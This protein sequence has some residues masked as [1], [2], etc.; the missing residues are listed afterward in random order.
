MVDDYQQGS[1]IKLV[2]NPDYGL[3]EVYLDGINIR[4]LPDEAQRLNTLTTGGIH[5]TMSSD[6]QTLANV[7]DG[8]DS[9]SVPQGGGQAMFLNQATEP[10]SDLRARQA[11][12]Y[13]VDAAALNDSLFGG[14]FDVVDTLFPDDSPWVGDVKLTGGDAAKAQEL[15][16]ELGG[17]SFSLGVIPGGGLAD[18]APYLQALAEQ[19]DNVDI[20]VTPLANALPLREGDFQASQ[21]NAP[22]FV[23]PFPT[24]AN[25]FAS[26]GSSNFGKYS[27]PEMDAALADAQNATSDADRAAAYEKINQL[28]ADDVP[29]VF[30]LRVP[31]TM[32]FDSEVVGDVPLFNDGAPDW[33]KIWL[34]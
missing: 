14:K 8:I 30:L 11:L 27:N 1:Q 15:I 26:T 21:V 7:P 22:R 28:L 32:L 9:K 19:F 23:A 17:L 13:M 10:F 4:F 2:K 6:P 20:E 33:S 25:Y 29:M 31:P 24:L 5:L 18:F 34:R 16:D 12:A 3:G